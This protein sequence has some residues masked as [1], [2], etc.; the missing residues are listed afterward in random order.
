MKCQEKQVNTV[1]VKVMGSPFFLN[2]Y[3][4][5]A[6]IVYMQRGDGI[7]IWYVAFLQTYQ[8]T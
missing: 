1:K 4:K 7:R 8:Q 5:N 3:A 6:K 2:N